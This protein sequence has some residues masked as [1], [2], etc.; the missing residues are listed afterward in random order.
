MKKVTVSGFSFYQFDIFEPF[1]H[2]IVHGVFP[3]GECDS[4]NVSFEHGELSEVL[5]HRKIICNALNFLS[6]SD[7][8]SSGYSFSLISAKQ[9]HSD[10]ITCITEPKNILHPDDEISDTDSF[11]SNCPQILL[12]VKTADCQPIL[13]YDPA[14]HVVANVHS[15]WRGTVQNIVGKTVLRLISDFGSMANDLLV[16]IGPSLSH[17]CS[18]F[19][20]RDRDF[21]GFESYFLS[22]NKVDLKKITLDQ[23][24]EIGVFSIECSD[25]C[26]KCFQGDFFSYRGD[27]PDR[28]RFASIIG[29]V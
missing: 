11:I 10:H 15:G 9:T 25:I 29:K 1:S 19:S 2:E 8:S 12:M 20:E 7:S 26:T 5:K 3:R 14:Q 22:D 6:S 4:L 23:L 16:G 18:E 28:G 17:C 27:R 13:I 24:R 21:K